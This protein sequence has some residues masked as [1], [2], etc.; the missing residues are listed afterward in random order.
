MKIVNIIR[1]QSFLFGHFRVV[2]V[3]PHQTAHLACLVLALEILGC[4]LE[5]VS[6]HVLS[7]LLGVDVVSYRVVASAKDRITTEVCT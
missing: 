7:K 6:L 4:I 3:V 5:A 2:V 1:P